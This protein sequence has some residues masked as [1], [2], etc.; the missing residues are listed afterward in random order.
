MYDI[1][2]I[3]GQA[4]RRVEAQAE[5][6]RMCPDDAVAKRSLRLATEWMDIVQQEITRREQTLEEFTT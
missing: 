1:Y 6:V 3:L 2:T 4:T 5:V